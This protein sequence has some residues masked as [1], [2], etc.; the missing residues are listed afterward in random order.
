VAWWIVCSMR[1]CA[2]GVNVSTPSTRPTVSLAM[3]L[4]KKAPWQQSWNRMKTR[5]MSAPVIAA[6][7]T[8]SHHDTASDSHSRNQ[9]PT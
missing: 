4:L 7:G 8:V 6:S 3:R 1:H 2:Y 5:T 9:R